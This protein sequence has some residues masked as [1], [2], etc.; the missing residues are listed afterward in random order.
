LTGAMS[1]W[2]E[3]AHHVLEVHEVLVEIVHG[4]EVEATQDVAMLKSDS[5]R[6]PQY[7]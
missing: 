3:Q 7:R 6:R 1:T 2:P 4:D 5:L